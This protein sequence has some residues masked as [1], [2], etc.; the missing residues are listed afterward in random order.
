MSE[1]VGIYLIITIVVNF[2]WWLPCLEMAFEY[3]L[4]FCNPK[5]IYN[6]TK[7]NWFGTTCLAILANAGFGPTVLCYWFYKLCTVGRR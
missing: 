4:C 3:G 5:W 1:I 7:T 6:H 2:I